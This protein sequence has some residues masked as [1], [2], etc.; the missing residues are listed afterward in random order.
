L[1]VGKK[2]R[3]AA[4]WLGLTVLLV[5]L[6][7]YVPIAIVERASLGNGFNYLGDTLMFCG[8]ILLLAGAE[9]QRNQ[10]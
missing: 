5:E 2:T 10:D 7:V 8:T 6:V 4:A 9:P 1:L 3:A